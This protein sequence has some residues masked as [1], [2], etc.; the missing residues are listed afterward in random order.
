M[1]MLTKQIRKTKMEKWKKDFITKICKEQ[2]ILEKKKYAIAYADT[3]EENQGY[4][5]SL[6]QRVKI[7][8]ANISEDDYKELRKTL[9]ITQ[10]GGKNQIPESGLF[11]L[12]SYPFMSLDGYIGI[13]K[14]IHPTG[15]L[16]IQLEVTEI[17]SDFLIKSTIECEEGTAQGIASVKVDKNG[18]KDIEKAASF[19]IRKAYAYLGFAGRWPIYTSPFSEDADLNEYIDFKRDKKVAKEVKIPVQPENKKTTIPTS[20]KAPVT[21]K[22]DNKVA[23]KKT[24]TVKK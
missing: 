9:A 1:W 10:W 11:C 23:N 16:N 5:M 4:I 24:T 8:N 18:K 19:A 2:K 15:K 20:V 17:G 12:T 3:K 6:E 13:Y 21:A 22:V 14:D 7:F